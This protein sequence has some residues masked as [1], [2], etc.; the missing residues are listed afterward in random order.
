LNA[1]GTALVL[2]ASQFLGFQQSIFGWI[3]GA[4]FFVKK[5]ATRIKSMITIIR[6]T[7][8]VV[9]LLP[10][11]DYQERGRNQILKLPLPEMLD[12]TRA[13]NAQ[14]IGKTL[15]GACAKLFADA[16]A[17]S[18]YKRL[19]RAE[20]VQMLGEEFVAMAEQSRARTDSSHASLVC[21]WGWQS[22]PGGLFGANWNVLSEFL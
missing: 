13:Y 8:D 22:L 6:A 16:S 7:I 3:N 19:E 11:E 1:I 14:D 21:D 10:G 20:A 15:H 5:R 2:E 12:V 18:Y 9:K 17:N 4:A